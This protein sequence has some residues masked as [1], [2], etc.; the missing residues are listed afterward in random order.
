MKNPNRPAITIVGHV[1]IDHNIVEGEYHE[2]WGSAAL[3]IAQYLEQTH[4]ITPAIIAPFGVDLYAF[5]DYRHFVNKP[6]LKHTLVYENTIIDGNRK[7]AVHYS[8][9]S[10]PVALNDEIRK[11]ISKTD[12]LI[13]APLLP[14]Y[15]AK[16]IQELCEILP[17]D[18][19]TILLP[20]GY[21]RH[22]G[23]SGEV[24]KRDFIEA[25]HILSHIDVLIQSDED[26][27][28]ALATAEQ[29]VKKHR[30]LTAIITQNL[31]GVTVFTHADTFAIPAD[32]VEPHKIINPVGAGDV[33]SAGLTI[34]LHNKMPLRDALISAQ[35]AAHHHIS[36]R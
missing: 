20:Q 19:Q 31:H 17:T 6:S 9:H 36:G 7:Q 1:C 18:A 13:L 23:R 2:S 28:N 8:E 21:Y 26:S 11:V 22:V 12:I 16:Y 4:A 27:S 32:P 29:W 30:Q 33:F 10:T 5:T 15:D 25:D 24:S 34:A 14:N 35:A 3:Y